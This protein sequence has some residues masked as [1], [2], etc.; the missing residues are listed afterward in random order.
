MAAVLP[1][2]S[3]AV[4]Y[5]YAFGDGRSLS[6]TSWQV[7]HVY[8]GPGLYPVYAQGVDALGQTHDNLASIVP[9]RVDSSYTPDVL[10][11]LAGVTGAVVSNGTSATHATALIP[12]GG[13]V[14]V[15]V[16]VVSPP[17]NPRSQLLATSFSVSTAGKP[18]ANFTNES[19]SSNATSWVTVGFAST[20]PSAVYDLTFSLPTVTPSHSAAVVAYSNFTFGIF[21]GSGLAGSDL[22]LPSSPH[23]G[24]LIAAEAAPGGAPTLDPAFGFGNNAESEVVANVYQS[25]IAPNGS[26][27]GPSPADFVPVLATCVPGSPLCASLYG[28]N[29]LVNG[30]NVTFVVNKYSKFYDSLNRHAWA[31]WPSDV[32]FSFLREMAFSDLGCPQCNSGW[33]LAQALLP[34][35]NGSWDLGLHVPFNTTPQHLY[36]SMTLNDSQNCPAAAFVHGGHGCITF[37]TQNGT[38]SAWTS[39]RAF[40]EFLANVQSGAV[41]PCGW[42]SA[43]AQGNGVPYW[44]RGN[45]TGS[46]DR[47]C[48]SPGTP[49]FGVAPANLTPTDW[50]AWEIRGSGYLGGAYLGNVQNESAGSGPYYLSGYRPGLGYNLSAN[51]SY[52]ATPTCTFAGCLPKFGTFDPQ[53]SVLWNGSSSSDLGALVNGGVDFAAVTP[54]D[55]G[56]LSH[57]VALGLAATRTVAT[58]GE[59]FAQLNLNYNVSLADRLTGRNLTAPPA[60]LADVNFRQFLVHAFP[61][62][63]AQQRV[64]TSRGLE[65]ISPVGGIL[66]GLLGGGGPSTVSWPQGDASPNASAVGSAGWWWARTASDGL[67]GAACTPKNPCSFPICFLNGSGPSARALALWASSINTLSNHSVTPVLYNVSAAQ[68]LLNNYFW[69]PGGDALTVVMAPTWR[70]D[71]AD[72]TDFVQPALY[73][74][75]AYTAGDALAEALRPLNASGCNTSAMHYARLGVPVSQGCQGAAYDAMLSALNAAA[76]GPVNA[77]ALGLYGEAEHILNALA[78]YVWVG[79]LTNVVAL[80][81]WIDPASANSNPLLGGEFNLWYDLRS[82]PTPGAPLGVRGP[83]SSVDPVGLSGTFTVSAL[84]TAG[85]GG[86]SYN[87]SGLPSRCSGLTNRTAYCQAAAPGLYLLNV[88]V[89]D[90]SGGQATSG[91]LAVIVLDPARP[92]RERLGQRRGPRSASERL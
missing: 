26:A 45:F 10:G 86:Y 81:P 38:G 35:G 3:L 68:Y 11:N 48:P 92:D 74:D 19:L 60:L 51:P 33:L 42:F 58:F 21:V 49:G 79:Q 30:T 76:R 32:M 44:T 2:G 8:S 25:L 20:T 65:A 85:T 84:A 63:S 22:P 31:V 5:R 46:G 91:V 4:S 12:A 89:T 62:A 67:A 61:Y 29:T 80:A 6:T 34:T 24:S 27:T 17:T 16:S 13:R 37:H 87:W 47:S 43:N 14:S 39:A 88:T 40:L 7:P 69:G 70:A 15:S 54:T 36:E 18:Y 28:G 90:Q 52:T 23:P 1:N 64:F 57:A 53:V 50:D 78:L 55:F 83:F 73:P 72:P 66:P 56:S 9:V 59:S 41:V 82:Y 77:S 71:Y 75:S